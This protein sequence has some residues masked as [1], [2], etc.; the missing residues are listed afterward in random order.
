[1]KLWRRLRALV[2]NG[3]LGLDDS[4]QRIALGVLLGFMVA[5]TPTL[6]LQIVI[7][8][9]LAAVLRV[10]KVS[11]VP[12]LFITNPF[13]AVPVYGACWWLGNIVLHGGRGESSWA[14]VRA[15]LLAESSS[16]ESVYEQ[17]LSADFWGRVGETMVQLGGELWV[18]SLVSG[19]ALGLPAYGLVLWGVR[20][21]RRHA[22]RVVNPDLT[23]EPSNE[24]EL[25]NERSV[26]SDPPIGPR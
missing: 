1:M 14:D 5:M 8:V 24:R 21:Y 9:A 26:S 10:N 2:V 17:L 4:P 22:D 3:I 12:I 11:G 20:A 23:P 6:G 25:L 16:S 15:R 19:V 7:Y 18:G 13:T